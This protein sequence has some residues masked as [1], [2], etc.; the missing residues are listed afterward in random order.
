MRFLTTLKYLWY[1]IEKSPA[2]VTVAAP[3]M[4]PSTRDPGVGGEVVPV[5]IQGVLAADAHVVAVRIGAVE[6]R[7]GEERLRIGGREAGDRSSGFVAIGGGGDVSCRIGWVTNEIDAGATRVVGRGNAPRGRR[8]RYDA[9]CWRL[10]R[11][12]VVCDA[13]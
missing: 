13:R 5:H 4:A 11:T 1:V 12:V 10:N 9:P 7:E 2:T 8:W 6:R 3:A